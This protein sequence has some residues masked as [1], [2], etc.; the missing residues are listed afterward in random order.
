MAEFNISGQKKAR[1][2]TVKTD[3]LPSYSL[4]AASHMAVPRGVELVCPV[5]AVAPANA[6]TENRSVDV[7]FSASFNYKLKLL[8]RLK[9][10]TA[11]L[12]A[13][14]WDGYNAHPIVAEA[15]EKMHSLLNDIPAVYLTRWRLFPAPNGTFALQAKKPHVAMVS[16]GKGRVSFTALKGERKRSGVEEFNETLLQHMFREIDCFLEDGQE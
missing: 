5:A 16:V 13:D 3:L 8:H 2:R 12:S 15:S 14:S 9:T 6:V 4:S 11:A 10:L 7:M 1:K